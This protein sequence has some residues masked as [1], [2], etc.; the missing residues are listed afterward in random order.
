MFGGQKKQNLFDDP[1]RSVAA[2]CAP[3]GQVV[4]EVPGPEGSSMKLRANSLKQALGY[5]FPE[6][7]EELEGMYDDANFDRIVFILT[8]LDDMPSPASQAE[9]HESGIKLLFETKL[10]SCGGDVSR[11]ASL[12]L[13][14][15]G[16]DATAAAADQAVSNHVVEHDAEPEGSACGASTTCE[17]RGCER[18][19]AAADA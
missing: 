14:R 4:T 19:A 18:D 12:L 13:E 16:R 6:L 1:G 9:L 11:K 2:E 8:K 3:V 17:E 15:W 5:G 10:Q 7:A